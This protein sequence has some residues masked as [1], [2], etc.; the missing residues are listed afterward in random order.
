MSTSSWPHSAARAHVSSSHGQPFSRPLQHLEVAA[1][2]RVRARLLVPRAAARATTSAHQG[3][4]I[5]PP[6]STSTRP[7]GSRF[8]AHCSTSRWPPSAAS[9]HVSSSHGQSF[10]A[11]FQHL[12][13]AAPRRARAR[14][15]HGQSFARAHFSTSRWPPR[16]ERARVLVPRAA[17][18]A[19]PLQHL[20]VA[21]PAASAHVD[22]PHGQPFSRAHFST[23]RWPPPAANAH[24][25]TSHG[26][27]F[28]PT[29]APRGGRPRRVR[30]RVHIPRAAARAR[31]FSVSRWPPSPRTRTSPRPTGS[32]S[33]AP[34]SAS[35]SGRP[36]PR[37]A[38]VLVPRA[39]VLAQPFRVSRWPPLA[40]HQHV[41][42]SHGQSFSRNHFSVSRWPP[43]PRSARP[44]VP[45]EILRA[46]RLQR[47]EIPV[48]RSGRAQETRSSA[49]LVD[50]ST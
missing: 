27:P 31:P 23:S 26:Q 24:V 49:Y 17:V 6:Q 44:F 22:V 11:P 16:R 42:S 18:L 40:A 48:P 37:R 8:R 19:R 4:Q 47:L 29:A 10:R 41:S 35:R 30:A 21:A 20:E 45:R 7:T 13:V 50:A 33:R 32:R 5:P 1:L 28:L 25:S 39:V 38:R 36:P 34:T 46:Q 9:A 12:E 43:P 14:S 15:S 3:G 2:R